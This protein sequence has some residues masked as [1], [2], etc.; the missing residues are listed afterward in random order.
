MIPKYEIEQKLWLFNWRIMQCQKIQIEKIV[1]E[2][3]LISYL[4][5]DG[6]TFDENE[7]FATKDEVIDALQAKLE[8]MR[9]KPSKSHFK[10]F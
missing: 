9:E 2:K 7:L 3:N 10:L 8:H 1:I 6:V 5:K 4:T